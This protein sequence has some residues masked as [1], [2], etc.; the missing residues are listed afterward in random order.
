MA[1]APHH[2]LVVV[3]ANERGEAHTI[4]VVI[5]RLHTGDQQSCLPALRAGE[6]I[7]PAD[8]VA[9]HRRN[10]GAPRGEKSGQE[11]SARLNECLRIEII[12]ERHHR[13]HRWLVRHG[14]QL[15]H[16]AIV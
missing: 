5:S 13:A 10:H 2:I 7:E 14:G 1:H 11:H 3:P 16:V 8:V 9:V 15:G 12:V 4:L 6:V